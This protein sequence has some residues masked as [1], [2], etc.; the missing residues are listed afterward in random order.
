MKKR[1]Q[2]GFNLI[3]KGK[4]NK[5]LYI[6]LLFI[7]LP[8]VTKAQ[9]LDCKVS[10][11]KSKISNSNVSYI[12]GLKSAIQN[13]IN[14]HNWTKDR[15]QPEERIHCN[16]QI[17][18]NSVDNN[19]NFKSNVVISSERPI[20]NTVSTT[21][22]LII[23]DNWDFKYTPN[24]SIVHNAFQYNDIASFLDFYSY[25]I[26]GYDY[27]TFSELGG[28]PYFQKA[29]NVFDV[30]QSASGKGWSSNAGSRSRY[31]LI[32]DLLDPNYEDLRKA[33]YIYHRHGLDL[34]TINTEKARS[35]IVD[36][37]KLIQ[38]AENQTTNTYLFDLF[39]NTKYNE[40]VSIFKDAKQSQRLEVYNLL[41]NIDQGHVSTY[42]Q[43]KSGSGDQNN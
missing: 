30:A 40:I 11:D 41:L 34:F 2:K 19:Y 28:T 38:K 3:P 8:V 18:L 32:T 23:S 29:R 36:A 22:V 25:I 14:N 21:P 13:Y 33:I 15:F 7:L 24:S 27:D 26:L 39:F 43:L 1:S 17:I 4:I 35:N 10:I 42:D 31:S 5:Y 37:L 12:S 9:E 20:Y 6:I 16:M